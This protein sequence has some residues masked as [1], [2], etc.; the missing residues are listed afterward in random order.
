[1]KF[2]RK[3]HNPETKRNEAQI[4]EYKDMLRQQRQDEFRTKLEQY[5]DKSE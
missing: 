3:L 1:M 4:Q 2:Q 5:E